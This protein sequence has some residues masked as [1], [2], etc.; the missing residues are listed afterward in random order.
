M[1]DELRAC[2]GGGRW[3]TTLAKVGIAAAQANAAGDLNPDQGDRRKSELFGE[4]DAGI[5][6]ASS[7][8]SLV[9]SINSCAVIVNELVLVFE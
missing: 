4:L 6:P 5:N 9:K 1:A 2:G 7:A 3:R 8:V